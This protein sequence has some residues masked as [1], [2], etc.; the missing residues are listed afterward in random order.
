MSENSNTISSS[1]HN[2]S[3]IDTYYEKYKDALTAF[4][5]KQKDI[6]QEYSNLPT[7]NPNNTH[8][9][10]L[11]DDNLNIYVNRIGMLSNVKNE[12]DSILN[13]CINDDR[14]KI[15]DSTNY[16]TCKSLTENYHMQPLLSL[17]TY[18]HNTSTALQLPNHDLVGESLQKD[19]YVYCPVD[20][21][22]LLKEGANTAETV[23]NDMQRG[24]SM[25]NTGIS[26]ARE[27]IETVREEANLPQPDSDFM[28]EEECSRYEDRS[29]KKLL[30]NEEAFNDFL[31]EKITG[32][33]TNCIG[34]H[35]SNN[36]LNLT[37]YSYSE[38][39]NDPNEPEN[40]VNNIT[41]Q[42][43]PGAL[44]LFVRVND[45]DNICI[46]Q[47]TKKNKQFIINKFLNLNCFE[48]S[49]GNPL[50]KGPTEL[51]LLKTEWDNNPNARVK[52]LDAPDYCYASEIITNSANPEENIWADKEGNLFYLNVDK[53]NEFNQQYPNCG[54]WKNADNDKYHNRVTEIDADTFDTIKNLDSTTTLHNDS[55]NP[56]ICNPPASNED[57]EEL[58]VLKE[59]VKIAEEDLV[60][61]LDIANVAEYINSEDLIQQKTLIEELLDKIEEDR[62]KW[63]ANI[64]LTKLSQ[65]QASDNLKN[66]YSNNYHMMA[67]GLVTIAAISITIKNL[68]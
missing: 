9:F 51:N 8:F 14:G 12:G 22:L 68:I 27:A 61:Q 29:T 21:S 1:L 62:Q 52:D 36:G 66:Y 53:N 5:K 10:P 4:Y 23:L 46:D 34:Y 64:P 11:V 6:L 45:S 28:S 41:I 60:Q 17:N 37:I 50:C 13:P 55:G 40:A 42:E 20:Q 67:W 15:S 2:K 56:I 19:T 44:Y 65:V 54:L 59:N 25:E 43:S 30:T 58:H 18:N 39:S 35:I 49:A 38:M 7:D 31:V 33:P 57:L 16:S 32:T 24:V 47:L 63:K 48:S 3:E 26:L